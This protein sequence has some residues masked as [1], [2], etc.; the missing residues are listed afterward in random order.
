MFKRF[1]VMISIF[2]LAVGLFFSSARA[3]ESSKPTFGSV[4]VEKVFAG[5]NKAKQ[6]SQDLQVYVEQM[7]NKL[8]E[9]KANRL[10]STEEFNQLMDLETK[11]N[12]TTDDKKKTE[13]IKELSRQRE[14]ELEGLQ[15]K[16]DL[17]TADRDRLNELQDQI[18]KTD[19]ALQSDQDKYQKE[20]DKR[21][22]DFIQQGLQD[23]QAKVA[24]VAKSKGISIVF[25]RNLGDAMFVIYSEVD[26]TEDVITALNKK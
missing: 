14:Q 24:S 12:P 1:V 9:R 15:Q 7:R 26:V 11:A 25:T 17:T 8:T 4:D 2:G 16:K 19:S 20:I 3:A 10:L 13:Q 23:I 5:Y 22:S 21:K 18:G 6:Q